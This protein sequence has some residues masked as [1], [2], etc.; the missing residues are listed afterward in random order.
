MGC[1]RWIGTDDSHELFFYLNLERRNTR[2]FHA[3]SGENKPYDVSCSIPFAQKFHP[4]SQDQCFSV[5]ATR[6]A[7]SWWLLLVLV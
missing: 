3:R 5:L 6:D 2:L 4:V 7:C 1:M